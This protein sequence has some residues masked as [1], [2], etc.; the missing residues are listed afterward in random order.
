M[1]SNSIPSNRN[2]QAR[3]NW[4]R[5]ILFGS[6]SFVSLAIIVFVSM[7]ENE[8]NH[9]FTDLMCL[10]FLVSFIVSSIL[11]IKSVFFSSGKSVRWY[12]ITSIGCGTVS[13]ISIFIF[14]YLAYTGNPDDDITAII[15]ISTI[16]I[17][18]ISLIL[19][20]VS[21]VLWKNTADKTIPVNQKSAPA[22]GV[23]QPTTNAFAT[24]VTTPDTLQGKELLQQYYSFSINKLV[25]SI[26]A[27][28]IPW[29]IV[30][31]LLGYK[32]DYII[33][34]KNNTINNLDRYSE[35]LLN[36]YVIVIFYLLI[37]FFLFIIGLVYTVS[38]WKAWTQKRYLKYKLTWFFS[39]PFTIKEL[40]VSLLSDPTKLRWPF[41]FDNITTLGYITKSTRFELVSL[42][43]P[44]FLEPRKA[45]AAQ[46]MQKWIKS[47]CTVRISLE[48]YLRETATAILEK[49]STD[50]ADKY[51]EYTHQLDKYESEHQQWWQ[52]INSLPRVRCSYCNGSGEINDSYATKEITER[53]RCPTCGGNGKVIRGIYEPRDPTNPAYGGAIYR[54][55]QIVA[56]STCDGSGEVTSIIKKQVTHYYSYPCEKCNGSGRMLDF[57]RLP[58]PI[59]PADPDP[60]FS[61]TLSN[62]LG[63]ALNELRDNINLGSEGGLFLTLAQMQAEKGDGAAAYRHLEEAMKWVS[64]TA[65]QEYMDRISQLKLEIISTYPEV[66][67]G[68]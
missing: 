15:G 31:S 47:D 39:S 30:L 45:E 60:G 27:A 48:T 64:P 51:I 40:V 61:A 12:K 58:E 23:S 17:F 20:I 34:V 67:K 22:D 37:A 41:A 6:I 46:V 5:A 11:T 7:N 33:N 32:W 55:Q 66:I 38:A 25:K 54:G 28:I 24:T 10:V 19:T 4:F 53:K 44:P 26:L 21:I 36:P 57:K 18:I 16:V 2:T 14:F 29:I 62:L 63:K 59:K 52:G 49:I 50:Q 8:T 56:C 68:A 43:I 3:P 35:S 13:I 1:S 65:S 42:V 9:G